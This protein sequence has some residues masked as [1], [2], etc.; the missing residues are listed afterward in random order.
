MGLRVV[1]GESE[2]VKD[3]LRR[4]ARRMWDEGVSDELRLRGPFEGRFES[5]RALRRGRRGAKREQ[6][7][8]RASRENL[9]AAPSST[10]ATQPG[11]AAGTGDRI[12]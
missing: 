9:G 12:V 5:R 1:V 8:V 10:R 11:A 7:L 3:A 4:L 2:S 6:E